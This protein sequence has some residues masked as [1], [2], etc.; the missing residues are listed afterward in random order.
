MGQFLPLLINWQLEVVATLFAKRF[1]H[2][3]KLEV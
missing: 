1:S 3:L 2:K